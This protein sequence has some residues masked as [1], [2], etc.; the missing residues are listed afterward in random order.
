MTETLKPC[1]FCGGKPDLGSYS[2]SRTWIVVCSKCEA[3]TQVYETKREAV[4]AWNARPIEDAKTEEIERLKEICIK[5]QKN[6]SVAIDMV[7]QAKGGEKDEQRENARLREAL[8]LIAK[9]KFYFARDEDK[10]QIGR[11]YKIA[12]EALKG[13]EE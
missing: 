6:Y 4:K 7:D 10:E 9:A 2:S 11:I 5:M 8:E 12:K 3:E 13:G 1:P